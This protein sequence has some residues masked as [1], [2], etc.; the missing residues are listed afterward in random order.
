MQ[1]Q[2]TAAGTK[3][4]TERFSRLNYSVLGQ[5]GLN[6]SECGFGTY[7]VHV[8][9]DAHKQA[10]R[11]ALLNGV[12]LIDT[13]SNYADGGSEELIGQVLDELL[14]TESVKREEIVVV[15]KAGYLQGQNYRLSQE[16][17]EQGKPI[18]E[19][20]EI[21]EGLEHCIH[22]EFLED[23]ITRSLK[24]L[25]LDCIDV[26]LLHNP[27][28]Y[29]NK[30][31]RSGTNRDKARDEYYRRIEKAFMHLEIEVQNGR[32]GCYGISSNTFPAG[33][34]DY[35][36][37]SLERVHNIAKSISDKN[38]FKVI[39]LPLNLLEHSAAS[40][41]NQ[42]ENRTVL[43]YA[44]EAGIAVLIN[45]PLNA[46][47]NRQL[48]RLINITVNEHPD[49]ATLQEY[50]DKI[51]VMEKTFTD[52]ILPNLKVDEQTQNDLIG[53]F[54]TGTYMSRNWPKFGPYWSWV[55]HQAQYVAEQ[56]SYAVQKLNEVEDRGQKTIDWL[57]NYV[58]Q[59][60]KILDMLTVIYAERASDLSARIYGTLRN[61][62]IEWDKNSNGLMQLALRAIRSSRGVSSVLVGMRRESYVDDVLTELAIPVKQKE[63]K[64]TWRLVEEK[65]S[66]Q[67]F[68]AG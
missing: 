31:Q 25:N 43:Q 22:P 2:A 36:F 5:T 63:H 35:Q 9:I 19:L 30:A 28:Y 46:F 18:P 49:R 29:M 55:E 10:L 11:K 8:S 6:V 59:F 27:E 56:I 44:H 33:A 20:V 45:R 67:T 12:N 37:T 24:R 23:Q 34:D 13:S 42:T 39:Q 57:D 62:S 61:T 7:R 41:V 3:R 32:I 52:E 51:C 40:R 50:F 1:K 58:E 16:L 54:S 68:P 66:K 26:F 65:L 47:V 48:L 15:S 21:S 4:Y 64:S 53:I 17:E 38:N 14:R 60:N